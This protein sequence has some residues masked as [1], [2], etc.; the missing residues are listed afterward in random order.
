M[1]GGRA[2][3][4]RQHSSTAQDWSI[5]EV[6][7]EGRKGWG[8]RRREE[9]GEGE[10]GGSCTLLQ[11]ADLDESAL[12]GIVRLKDTLYPSQKLLPRVLLVAA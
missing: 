9:G 2:G 7:G 4:Y 5:G 12:G 6:R 10:G 11:L 1:A 8:K 3:F